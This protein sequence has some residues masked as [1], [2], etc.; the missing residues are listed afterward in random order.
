MPLVSALRA[1]PA[2][3]ATDAHAGKNDARAGR[4]PGTDADAGLFAPIM[5]RMRRSRPSKV[6]LEL[7]AITGRSVR[8]AERWLAGS[9]TPDGDATLALFLSDMGP[10]FLEAV[11]EQLP[12]ARR[13]AFWREM[14]AAW[15]RAD[16]RARQDALA[17]EMAALEAE[18]AGAEPRHD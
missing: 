3:P 15:K 5:R 2:N 1:S 10:A 7:S 18:R 12:P 4:F 11:T 13:E 17:R 14:G 8:T 6:A 16:L 9:L